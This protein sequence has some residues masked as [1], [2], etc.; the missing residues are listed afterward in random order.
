LYNDSLL[1]MERFILSI[2]LTALTQTRE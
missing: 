1:I 2:K